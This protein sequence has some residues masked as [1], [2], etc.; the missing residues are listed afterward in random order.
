M[1]ATPP[2][3]PK[4]DYSTARDSAQAQRE[5]AELFD[6]CL[7]ASNVSDV[8]AVIVRQSWQKGDKYHPGPST[9]DFVSPSGL[10]LHFSLRSRRNVV[11][12]CVS[13]QP[14]S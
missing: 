6:A 12:F 14:K 9:F 8:L 10:R 13:S 3:P 11:W 1:P 2:P 7:Y 5:I 4:I